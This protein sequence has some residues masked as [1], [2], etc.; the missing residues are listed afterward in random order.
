MSDITG[1]HPYADE[2][3]M[4]SEDELVGLTESIS[5]SGLENPVVVARSVGGIA[6]GRLVDGRN[7]R[8]AC[9]RAGV[10]LLVKHK[11]FD[12]DDA[13]KEWVIGVNTTGRRE[14]MTVQ[15]AAASTALILG[16]ER[17]KDGRW[18]NPGGRGKRGQLSTVSGGD[19]PAFIKALTR[20]G[21]I[22]DT[23]GRDALREVRDCVASLNSVYERAVEA[24][25]EERL[26]RERLAKEAAEEAAAKTFVEEHDPELAA[27]VGT[28]LL[29]HV[30]AKAVWE[31]RNREQ[32][33]AIR[34]E[35]AMRV[36]ARAAELSAWGKA[37]DGLLA[38]L[39]YAAASR[40]PE[41]TDRYTAVGT[42]IERY[43]ALGTH[44][45]TWKENQ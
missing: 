43:E 11:D 30:E 22:L 34:Q 26:E 29:S 27:L 21:L 16:E 20:C 13:L 40:P 23:L 41:D 38:A 8:E 45:T 28:S 5:T 42:F 2:F 37:C 7:R 9:S 24:R 1:V 14:S 39:S 12:S 17:R 19:E 36:A 44:I 35:E 25:E 15:I 4:A 18:D 32:A 3:P 6:D 10:E 31:K 33:A